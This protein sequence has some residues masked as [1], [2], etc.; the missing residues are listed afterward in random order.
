MRSKEEYENLINFSPLFEVDRNANPV[1]F[2]TEWRVFVVLLTELYK[3]YDYKGRPLETYS[4]ELMEC[5]NECV[6]YYDKSKGELFLHLFRSVLKN[7][8]LKSKA[9]NSIDEK[10]QGIVLSHKADLQIRKIMRYASS[11]G[12]DVSNEETQQKIAKAVGLD[13]ETVKNLIYINNNATAVSDTVTN[14]D[15]DEI[16]LFDLQTSDKLT[17]EEYVL[18]EDNIR[19]LL[20]VFEEEYNSLQNR[21]KPVI[22][23]LL[24]AKLIA[25]I[26]DSNKFKKY[27]NGFSYI[28]NSMVEDFITDKTIP[29]AKEIAESFNMQESGVS[30]ILNTFLNRAQVK[31]NA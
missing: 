20:N 16:S 17:P 19:T 15:G 2:D 7:K 23:K 11:H 9:R 10:R 13:I 25:E 18:L 12:K 29:T 6:K 22:K 30:R 4:L 26:E 28:D 31:I 27:F 5:A 3:N 24:T 8:I 14:E 1:L 21:T